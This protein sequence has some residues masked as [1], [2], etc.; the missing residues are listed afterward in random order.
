MMLPSFSSQVTVG[1]D[2]DP[3]PNPS[4][5]LSN[6]S[7]GNYNFSFDANF[8]NHTEEICISFIESGTSNVIGPVCLSRFDDFDCCGFTY[9][10]ENLPQS[11]LYQLNTCHDYTVQV[12]AKN[13]C[14]DTTV[15]TSFNWDRSQTLAILSVPNVITLPDPETGY[16]NGLNDEF[17]I[18]VEGAQTY[19]IYVSNTGGVVHEQTGPVVYSPMC[20][21]NGQCTEF[22]PCT[23]TDLATGS[24]AVIVELTGCNTDTAYNGYV[25]IAYDEDPSK[26]MVIQP[27]DT[28]GAQAQNAGGDI[29]IFPNPASDKVFVQLSPN[30][31][32]ASISLFNG[33]GQELMKYTC[34]RNVYE[35]STSQL[36]NGIYFL[37]VEEAQRS[38]EFKLLISH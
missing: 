22:P 20:I 11:I 3:S 4:I 16:S 14:F 12:S 19:Y 10:Y 7:T 34:S 17:C 38:K 1:W 28:T 33:I 23:G 24:Y 13:F 31:A 8:S 15:T 35:L 21:W 36:P 9:T 27:D 2:S 25:V 6:I 37:K 30:T 32:Y 26:M 18:E 29:R 5:S